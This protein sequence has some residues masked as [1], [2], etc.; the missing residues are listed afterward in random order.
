MADIG[1]E[2]TLI[3]EKFNQPC[4]KKGNIEWRKQ[5]TTSI[6]PDSYTLGLSEQELAHIFEY[7]LKLPIN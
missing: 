3:R 6:M 4:Y 2:L 1:P 5:F 7:L